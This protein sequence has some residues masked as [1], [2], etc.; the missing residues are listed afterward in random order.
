[1]SAIG[2]RRIAAP[3]SRVTTVERKNLG[4]PDERRTPESGVLEPGW[5]WPTHMG[6]IEVA[7]LVT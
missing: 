6:A 2:A 7:R 1:M 4:A 3:L 5:R